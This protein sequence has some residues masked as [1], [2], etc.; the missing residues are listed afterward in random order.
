MEVVQC[1]VGIMSVVLN[2]LH[3]YLAPALGGVCVAA[4][5]AA[6]GVAGMAVLMVVAMASVYASMP[7]GGRLL[8][9]ITKTAI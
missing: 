4:A 3:R 8:S 9:R 5:A 6:D 7:A 1:E 2:V